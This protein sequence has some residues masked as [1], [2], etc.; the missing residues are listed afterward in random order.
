MLT[1]S[2]RKI[3]RE[4]NNGN[5]AVIGTETVFG[6]FANAF[7]EIAVAKIF[8]T[9]GRPADN[10]LIVHV[11]S[12]NQLHQVA[13]N[14]DKLSLKVIKAFTPGPL[15]IILEKQDS[16]PNI[17]SANLNTVAVR[18]P[19][20]KK[21]RSIIKKTGPIAGP[22][23]N[24]S[25]KPSATSWRMANYYF[26]HLP[27]LLSKRS[28]LGI[29]STVIKVENNEIL[30]LRP[31]SI[32]K[33]MI[34]ERF[35]QTK[36]KIAKGAK[37][38]PGT[39]YRHYAPEKPLIICENWPKDTNGI[40]L[41]AKNDQPEIGT[42][43]TLGANNSEIGKNLYLSLF[44]ADRAK[45]DKIYIKLTNGNLSREINEKILRASGRK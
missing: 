38:S 17:T 26:P 31:G 30:I 11:A 40:F 2:K 21:L 41:C 45:G 37:E 12:I 39:R 33:S 10:P 24:P 8:K 22:S 32:T 44:K 4:I 16:L 23:A 34:E 36:V 43:L 28:R 15:T 9:K 7:N 35:P 18:I 1:L 6:I 19:S 3:I 20:S 14:I 25:G 13:K 29:E 42:R 5:I 27:V